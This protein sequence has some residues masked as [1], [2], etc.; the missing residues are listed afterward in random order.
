MP[1]YDRL[2]GFLQFTAFQCATFGAVFFL[3]P[4]WFTS[5]AYDWVTNIAPMWVFGVA[6]LTLA[7]WAV[8]Y[9]ARVVTRGIWYWM[10]L[11][12]TIQALFAWSIF[13]LTWHGS[14]GAFTGTLMWGG[15]A[16]FGLRGLL[17]QSTGVR[18]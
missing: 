12:C 16:Y 8:L 5:R 2:R 1:T 17:R 15:Y 9:L 13:Y 10:A 7:V 6:W 11:Y 4:S 18:P 3:R 14:Q